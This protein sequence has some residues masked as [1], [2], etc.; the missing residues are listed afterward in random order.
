ME[1]TSSSKIRLEVPGPAGEEALKWRTGVSA[2]HAEGILDQLVLLEGVDGFAAGGGAGGAFAA[3]VAD[4]V[5]G[6]FFEEMAHGEPGAH[7]LRLLLAP[8]PLVSGTRI[9][10]AQVVQE[11]AVQWVELL[12]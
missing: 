11:F 2:L 3:G 5:L 7:V 1:E 12:D 10:G 9:L 4:G 8:D 6:D